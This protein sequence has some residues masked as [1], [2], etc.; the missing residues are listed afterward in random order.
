MGGYSV[1]RLATACL[2]V[3]CLLLLLHRCS[4]CEARKLLLAA[5]ERGG[6]E[7]M[8]FE[9]GL[10]LRVVGRGGGSGRGVGVIESPPAPA[11]PRGFSASGSRAER[12]MRSVPSPG[13]GH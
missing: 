9:G 8:H 10:V 13:V 11:R 2:A 12:L 3:M 6:D 5:E 1:T 7:V 4:P